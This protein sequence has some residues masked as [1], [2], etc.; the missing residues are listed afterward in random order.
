MTNLKDTI[1]DIIVRCK[2]PITVIWDSI[3]KKGRNYYSQIICNLCGFIHVRQLNNLRKGKFVCNNC[4]HEEYKSRSETLG[5]EYL[6]LNRQGKKSLAILKCKDDGTIKEVQTGTLMR[7]NIQ[8]EECLI[9]YYQSK[10]S[11][12]NC[13]YISR[14]I[15]GITFKNRL[16]EIKKIQ[17]GA[18]RTGEWVAENSTWENPSIVYCFSFTASGLDYIDDGFYFKIGF[19]RYPEKRLA[20]LKLSI[21]A[22]IQ[23]IEYAQSRF[24]ARKLEFAMHTK[25]L[26]FKLDRNIAKLF[27]RGFDNGWYEDGV[28][29]RGLAGTTEW[30]YSKNHIDINKDNICY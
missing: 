5:F 18:I 7:N 1:Q 4:I 10:L 9:R 22:N 20:K 3:F 27:T 28:R 24:D 13:T 30:F 12:R 14:D 15:K 16:G 23:I 6:G 17:S 26:E 21:P 29:V 19:S 11:E 8:C 2:L 25:Y